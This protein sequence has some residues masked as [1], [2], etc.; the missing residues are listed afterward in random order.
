MLISSIRRYA[1]AMSSLNLVS[2][3]NILRIL[4]SLNAMHVAQFL[5]DQ[6]LDSIVNDIFVLEHSNPSEKAVIPFYADGFPGL[7]FQ[8]TRENAILFPSG[9]RLSDFFLY[10]QTIKPIQIAIEAPYRLIIFQLHPYAPRVLFGV[11]PQ[12]LN[13]DCY[14]LC[15]VEEAKAT[16]T[17]DELKKAE[18][19]NDEIACISQ[20]IKT[21]DENPIKASEDK[22]KIAIEL[23]LAQKGRITVKALTE[24]LYMTERTLQRRFIEHIGVSP[25]QFAKIVQFQSSMSHL[26]EDAVSKLTDIVYQNGYTDQSY[27]IKCF[28]KFT[29]IKPSAFR[30]S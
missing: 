10:G 26:S 2:R 19:A 22:I 8:K 27:F 3:W 14:D 29:G 11:N 20:F 1:I 18:N 16:A 13:D 9:K 17:V 28:K 12:T 15:L 24:Q 6:K 5:K 23:I 4:L 25:K 7:M 30:K 21:L